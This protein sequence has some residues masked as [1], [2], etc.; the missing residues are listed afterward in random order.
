MLLLSGPDM[1]ERTLSS[2]QFST[3]SLCRLCYF[4]VSRLDCSTPFRAGAS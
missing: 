1:T 4:I 2:R 3:N